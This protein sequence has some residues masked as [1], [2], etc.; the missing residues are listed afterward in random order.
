MLDV[1]AYAR[2]NFMVQYLFVVS[3]ASKSSDGEKRLCFLVQAYQ[4]AKAVS[5]SVDSLKL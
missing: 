4:I 1:H 3:R 2:S 5:R